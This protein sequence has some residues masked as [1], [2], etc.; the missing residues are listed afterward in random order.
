M[1]A[2]DDDDGGD[3]FNGDEVVDVDEENNDGN[4]LLTSQLLAEARRERAELR[5][6]FSLLTSV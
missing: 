3:D 6:A 5:S 4:G 1:N 2:R